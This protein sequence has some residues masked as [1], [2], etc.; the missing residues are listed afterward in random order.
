MT[1]DHSDIQPGLRVAEVRQ[2]LAEVAQGYEALGAR[3]LAARLE[4]TERQARRVIDRLRGAQHRPDALRVV[5]L[6]V[7]I[8]SG[9]TREAWHVLWPRPT[10][11]LAARPTILRCAW[12]PPLPVPGAA[13]GS[14]LRDQ[15]APFA[16]WTD[17]HERSPRRW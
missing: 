10:E 16:P 11:I 3:A 13:Q 4:V 17:A 1:P 6:P 12:G 9:A 14:R 15:P 8:G 2:P 7:R 5:R